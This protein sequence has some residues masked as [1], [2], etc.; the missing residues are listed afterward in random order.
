[1]CMNILCTEDWYSR[2]SVTRTSK[3]K[4]KYLSII[5]SAHQKGLIDQD[6]YN[7][8]NIWTVECQ[9]FTHCQKYTRNRYCISSLTENASRLVDSVLMPQV[10]CLLSYTETHLTSSNRLVN[11][12][13]ALFVTLDVEALYSSIPHEQGIGLVRTFLHEQDHPKWE[14]CEFIWDLLRFILT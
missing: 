11:P 3:F 10:L 13:D 9:L 2:I 5:N 8:L 6:L 14:Y 7:Y 12:P 1:M 4:T